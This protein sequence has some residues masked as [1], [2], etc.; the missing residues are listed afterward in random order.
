MFYV[1]NL[2]RR[3]DRLKQF[4]SRW[5]NAWKGEDPEIVVV[6][7]VDGTENTINHKLLT[8]VDVYNNDFYNNPR[9]L[10]TIL[11][12]LDT[13]YRIAHGPYDYGVI[14]EDDIL[15]RPDFLEKWKA[16]DIKR[17]LRKFDILYIG[18]GDVLPMHTDCI[19]SDT[20]YRSQEK[21]HVTKVKYNAMGHPNYNS[22]YLFDWL[23]AFGY[24]ITKES[25]TKLL[26]VIKNSGINKAIDVWL[27]ENVEPKRQYISVPLLVYHPKYC[28]NHYDSDTLGIGIPNDEVEI[29][30]PGNI[31]FLIPTYK[32]PNQLIKTVK[33]IMN[34][35]RW[36]KNITF[37]FYTVFGDTETE[38]VLKDLKKYI[39]S[40]G[41]SACHMSGPFRNRTQLHDHYNSLWRCY[42]RM[43]DFFMVWNDHTTLDTVD[44]DY[45][46]FKHH[47]YLRNPEIAAYTYDDKLFAVT[48]Q[49]F[50]EMG[51]VS[52]ICN[53][54]N[55]IRLLFG[56][57]KVL[58]YTKALKSTTEEVEYVHMD[59]ALKE[60]VHNSLYNSPLTKDYMNKDLLKLI[61]SPW[62]REC[63]AWIPFPDN[64]NES[65][66]I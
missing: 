10:A 13:W 9:I 41:S 42:F 26:D 20:L 22:G 6:K 38:N 19:K 56:Y 46:L 8:L 28:S 14:M 59:I 49:T 31:T 55:Y 54:K 53:I 45:Q 57:G 37:A 11:S 44:W 50:L 62:Y 21:S 18:A 34:N 24:C 64:W 35:A 17:L 30:K 52:P 5:L 16:M 25:A 15:F 39:T 40:L 12:H 47:Y 1:I 60:F 63:G 4:T 48:N 36:P 27:K 58:I 7:A 51:K 61:K 23:G 2:P 33:T 43:S 29:K 32:R 66:T 65:K 3:T